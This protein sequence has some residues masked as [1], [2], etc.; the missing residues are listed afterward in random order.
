ML[1][2]IGAQRVYLN[3]FSKSC[4]FHISCNVTVHDIYTRKDD[5]IYV[6]TYLIQKLI[7]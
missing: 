3:I 2:T 7:M 6:H 4:Q 1:V 5:A